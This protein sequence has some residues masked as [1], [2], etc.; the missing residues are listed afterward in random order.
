MEF[1]EVRIIR[2]IEELGLL[3][4]EIVE[5]FNSNT[6]YEYLD[7]LDCEDYFGTQGWKYILGCE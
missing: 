5:A 4:D 3:N 6:L 1:D 7:I 2:G